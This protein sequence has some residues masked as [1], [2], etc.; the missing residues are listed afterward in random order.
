[1]VTLQTSIFYNL[2]EFIESSPLYRKYHLLFQC[3]DLSEIPDRNKGVGCTGHSRRAICRAFIVKHL[4]EIKTVPRLIEYLENYPVIAELCGFDMRKKLPDE[5]QFY[6]FLKSTKNSLLQEIYY[7]INK[8]LVEEGIISLDTFIMDSKPVLAASK[9]N[10]LKNPHRNT[11]NKHKKPKRNPAATL[12]YY[13]Y[14]NINGTK[15]NQIFYWGYRTHVIIT[16]QGIPLIELTL[17][18]NQTDAKVAK[19]L[20]KK[21]KR[22]YGLKKG[23]IFIADAGY[24]EKDLYD[25][26]V[27]QLKCQAF[28]PLNPRNTQHDKQFSSN[29]CPICDAGLEMK[30]NG[31][32]TEAKRTRI[33]YRCPLKVNNK[34]AEQY[35]NGCPIGHSRFVDGKQ[36]GCTKYVDITNDA[37]A[38]VPRDSIGYKQTYQLRTEVERYF[39]RLGD[40]EVEQ[41]THYN[42]KSIKNQMTIAHLSL[43]LIAF[44]A[45]VLMKQPD[46]IR[47]Y[48]TFAHDYIP[49]NIAA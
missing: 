47:C 9:D 13:S 42:I 15:K 3:L 12:G 34:L 35:P 19:K 20:I 1:M 27:E 28:I 25:F 43:S 48:R 32:I 37:R 46:K 10:N 4:E 33:K 36:Y 49:L 14:Q 30:S 21:L 40:R 38:R 2:Q 16:K 11:T 45:A 17:P 22:V 31:I 29:G 7:R 23:S 24:D 6:R 5:T 8:K 39:S 41:T 18:N 26:I 44:A